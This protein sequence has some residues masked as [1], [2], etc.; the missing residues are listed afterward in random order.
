VTLVR[1]TYHYDEATQ[2]MV[3]GPAP[4]R[5]RGSGDGWRYNDRIYSSAPFRGI[6]GELINSRKS[7]REYMARHSLTTADDFTET[8]KKAAEDR[9]KP[10]PSLKQDVINAFE[11]C[12]ASEANAS[13]RARLEEARRRRPTDEGS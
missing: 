1:R 10:D 5:S 4:Q 6:H 13:G 3:E 12:S 8:W 11:K 9:Q 7:H 2:T